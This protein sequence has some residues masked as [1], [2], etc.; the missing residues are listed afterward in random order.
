MSTNGRNWTRSE[1]SGIPPDKIEATFDDAFSDEPTGGTP[2]LPTLPDTPVVANEEAAA[3][4]DDDVDED[5]NCT[6]PAFLTACCP[7]S[8]C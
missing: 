5:D 8:A 1:K 2:P 6:P 7:S 4:D 3:A